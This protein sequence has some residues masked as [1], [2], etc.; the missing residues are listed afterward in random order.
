MVKFWHQIPK[1]VEIVSDRKV[2]IANYCRGKKVLHVGCA[3][4]GLTMDRLEKNSL[5]HFML[6]SEAER[7][8]G[9]DLDKNGLETRICA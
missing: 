1:D 5:L 6:L 9:V 2:F 4:A 8:W 3:D 7:V